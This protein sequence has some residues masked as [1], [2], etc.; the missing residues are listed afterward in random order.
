MCY[1]VHVRDDRL[2]HNTVDRTSTSRRPY[3]SHGHD[4]NGLMVVYPTTGRGRPRRRQRRNG[5]YLNVL[6]IV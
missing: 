6:P 3:L 4:A 2:T 5:Y 1:S